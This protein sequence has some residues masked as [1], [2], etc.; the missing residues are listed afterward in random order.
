MNGNVRRLVRSILVF[1]PRGFAAARIIKTRLQQIVRR[2]HDSDFR[3]LDAFELPP[4]ALIL[5]I[6]ANNGQAARSIFSVLPFSRVVSFEPNP[7]HWAALAELKGANRNYS[8]FDCALAEAE[9]SMWLYW[10][11]YNGCEF[12]P[13]AS[14]DEKG[15]SAWLNAETLLGFKREKLAIK[16]VLVQVK[17]LDSFRLDPRFIKL[18]VEGASLRVLLGAEETLKRNR[19]ILMIEEVRRGDEVDAL[20]KR[21]EY[22]PYSRNPTSGSLHVDRYGD[23][24]TFFIPREHVW[25]SRHGK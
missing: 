14:L 16:K 25:V 22:V 3:A 18:D 21:L 24:N 7:M 19:P 10:P 11:V 15:A 4:G 20:L 6:G 5:D 8:Y 12:S 1:F 9:S 13:L 2:P 17:K 23:A